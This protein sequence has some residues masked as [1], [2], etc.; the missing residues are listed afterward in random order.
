MESDK[1]ERAFAALLSRAKTLFGD[2]L[3][4]EMVDGARNNVA[5]LREALRQ[6]LGATREAVAHK[7]RTL[8]D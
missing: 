4:E 3:T 1:T 8:D 5:R 6:K 2:Q 7:L